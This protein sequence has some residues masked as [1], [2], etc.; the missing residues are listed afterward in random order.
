MLLSCAA[1]FA[2]GLS[3]YLYLP[4]RYLAQPR[5][6]YARVLGLD[7]ADPADLWAM[8]GGH[9]FSYAMFAYSPAALPGEVGRFATWLWESFFGVGAIF[10]LVGLGVLFRARPGVAAALAAL[11]LA[12]VVFYVNYNVPN[13]ETMFLP[14]YLVW[15]VWVG[16]ALAWL[17]PRWAERLR[18]LAQWRATAE[19]DVRLALAALALVPLV[20]NYPRLDA[21]QDYAARRYAEAVMAELP[22]NALALG[23][24]LDITPLYYVQIVEGL[25]PDVWLYDVGLYGLG[26]VSRLRREG[27][28]DGGAMA[29][30][31]QAEIVALVEVELARRPV[32]LL[33]RSPIL[34]EQFEVQPSGRTYRIS[35]R[36]AGVE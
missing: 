9:A 24:W 26:R 14:A 13:K 29:E 35:A 18:A 2:L 15:S 36:R 33:G 32:Y 19:R 3:T 23:S 17:A 34:E 27:V 6:D 5:L 28:V 4:L 1:L 8:V 21:S 7:L 30:R 20:V 22:P 10:G 16:V 11:F 31:I 12:H 25:R